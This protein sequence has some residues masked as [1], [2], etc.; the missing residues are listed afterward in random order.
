M[1]RSEQSYAELWDTEQTINRNLGRKVD[2]EWTFIDHLIRH[3]S[4]VVYQKG[5]NDMTA[6]SLLFPW[7]CSF[8]PKCRRSK[9][10]YK[11]KGGNETNKTSKFSLIFCA[12]AKLLQ[13]FNYNKHH[14]VT[15]I[16]IHITSSVLPQQSSQRP[17]SGPHHDPFWMQPGRSHWSLHR[18]WCYVSDKL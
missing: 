10:A 7:K 16:K 6:N 13:W 2:L 11:R 12:S 8:T 9:H 18:H 14:S 1:S 3:T 5:I 17:N 4:S 15:L